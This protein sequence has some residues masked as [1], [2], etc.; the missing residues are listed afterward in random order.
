MSPW[1][2][3]LVACVP[4]EETTPAETDAP[5]TDPEPFGPT[6][7]VEDSGSTPVPPTD[8]GTPAAVVDLDLDGLDD[9][10][11]QRLAET[12]LPFL[13][14]APDDGCATMGI[15][16]R[17]RPHPLDATRIHVVYDLLYDIDCGADGHVGDNEVIAVTAAPDLPAPEGILAIRAIS[18]QDTL[19]QKVTDCGCDTGACETATWD[20][21][22][23]PVVYSSKDKHGNYLFEGPC[24]GACFFTNTCELAPAPTT[25][26]LVNAGEPG[27]PLTNDLTA[28]GLVTEANGWTSPEL[29][30]F[31]PWGS[32]D[33][34][35]AGNVADDLVDPAFQTSPC[36]GP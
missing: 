25:P 20:G 10:E 36:S 24:D 29:F 23:W 18:H 21:A 28:A 34:G 15:V 32:E 11:E 35:S 2:A 31:D 6:S 3:L 19:C 9:G 7:P 5:T 14:L 16:Y 22:E 13:S 27:A 17:L 30:G 8:T 33:F 4:A 12:Y 1:L 26:M